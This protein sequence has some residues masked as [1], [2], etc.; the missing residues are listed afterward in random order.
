MTTEIQTI[1][2]AGIPT[3]AV[4]IG[5]FVDSARLNGLGGLNVRIDDLR[6]HLDHRFDDLEKALRSDFR[7]LEERLR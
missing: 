4:V 5:V 7:R 3:L 1:L 2:S 6:T